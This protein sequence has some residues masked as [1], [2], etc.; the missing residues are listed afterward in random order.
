MPQIQSLSKNNAHEY[1]EWRQSVGFFHLLH[2]THRA[3]SMGKLIA[4]KYMAFHTHIWHVVYTRKFI[5]YHHE[6]M[7]KALRLVVVK[8]LVDEPLC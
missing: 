2:P 4:T 3:K 1:F 7:V 5:S 8:E 6:Y